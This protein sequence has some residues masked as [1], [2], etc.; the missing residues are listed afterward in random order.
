MA[1][2]TGPLMSMSASGTLGGTLTYD[3]RGFVRQ[4]V[5]PANPQTDAQGNVRQKLLAVQKALAVI[6]AAV[7]MAVK[8]IAPTSYRW[9]SFLL[10]QCIGPNSANFDAYKATFDALT[11]AQKDAWDTAAEGKGI[12][13]QTIT[14]ASDA[15]VRSGLAL[16]VVSTALFN[17]GINVADGVPG[18][19]NQTEWGNFFG[20]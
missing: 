4:H 11:A 20:T 5:I 18:A 14:Y 16:F 19:A 13:D 6:G 7:I 10:S 3:K 8:A 17:L 1:K 2:A 9:N 12:V 15:A